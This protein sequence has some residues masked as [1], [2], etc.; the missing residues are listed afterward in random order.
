MFYAMG[1]ALVMEG[2][3]SGSYHICPNHSNFQFDTAFMYTIAILCML[4][5]YQ[6][7]HPDINANGVFLISPL[8]KPSFSL[9]CLW[10]P[11][12]CHLHWCPW[13]G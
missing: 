13:R 11:R 9:H 12:L 7:R 6:F 8:L 3:M 10:R 5:I 1:F 4:K 2:L